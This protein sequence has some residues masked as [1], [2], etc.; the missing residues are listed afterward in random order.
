MTKTAK[1]A[2]MDKKTKSA[3]KCENRLKAIRTELEKENQNDYNFQKAET[4][5]TA[6]VEKMAKTAKVIKFAKLE[7]L[8]KK[9]NVAK[10]DKMA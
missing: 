2:K 9:A 7:N 8:A 6:N 10:L 4:G 3:K 1:N 5:K